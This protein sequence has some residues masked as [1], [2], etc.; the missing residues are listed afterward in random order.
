MISLPHF[1]AL[2]RYLDCVDQAISRKFVRKRP[3]TEP[4]LTSLLCDLLDDSVPREEILD[5]S[6][7][8]LENELR[9]T[10]DSVGVTF[11]IDT[12]EYTPELERWVTQADIGLV[13]RLL[14]FLTP[15]MSWSQAYLLQAKRLQ[16]NLRSA[17]VFSEN[18]RFGANDLQQ[19]TRL[20]KL[21]ELVGRDFVRYLLYAPRP[22]ALDDAARAYLARARNAAMSDRIFDFAD[23]HILCRDLLSA[24]PSVDAGVFVTAAASTPTTLL[25]VHQDMFGTSLPFAWFVAT[26]FL[27]SPDFGRSIVIAGPHVGQP[28]NSGRVTVSPHSPDVTYDEKSEDPDA[29]AHGIVTGNP[30][31]VQFALDEFTDDGKQESYPF[32]PRHTLRVEV[33]VGRGLNLDGRGIQ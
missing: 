26:H 12:H 28:P 13:I 22:Q 11:E 3:Y 14:D 4:H 8:D 24:S 6:R 17:P 9:N 10:R 20:T 7:E 31:A 19:H 29:L 1:T 33:S 32:L 18:S 30:A 15:S 5:F 25:R 2:V 16:P 21:A 23:G 27:D